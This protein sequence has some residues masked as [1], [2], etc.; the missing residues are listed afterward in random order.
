M[1]QVTHFKV[2]QMLH[3]V[4]AKQNKKQ[5]SR[6]L[7]YNNNE[8]LVGNSA[9]PYALRQNCGY[10]MHIK[11]LHDWQ[12]QYYFVYIH[13]KK[14]SNPNLIFIYGKKN[15][16]EKGCRWGWLIYIRVWEGAQW[17]GIIL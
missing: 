2:E 4:E 11:T 6:N 10:S 13:F 16:Y 7:P 14:S 8:L 3:K 9:M 17:V 15:F 12:L 1:I 5:Q